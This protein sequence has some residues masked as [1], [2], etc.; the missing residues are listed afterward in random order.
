MGGRKGSVNVC[1]YPHGEGSYWLSQVG[2]GRMSGREGV[3]EYI[4]HMHTHLIETIT[5]SLHNCIL[6]MMVKRGGKPHIIIY[7][8][9]Y[10]HTRIAHKH[11][12]L[13]QPER[14]ER[15]RG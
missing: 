15:E 11:A 4:V 2:Y 13:A 3:S 14:R 10:K 8:T 7:P 6:K 12:W 1:D 5:I 9:D